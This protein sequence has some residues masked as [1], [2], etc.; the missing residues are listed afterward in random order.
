MFPN[1]TKLLD[2]QLSHQA[3]EAAV[4][5]LFKVNRAYAVEACA[6]ASEFLRLGDFERAEQLAITALRARPACK[7]AYEVLGQLFDQQDRGGDVTECK[8]GKLPAQVFARHFQ[9]AQ[10]LRLAGNPLIHRTEVFPAERIPLPRPGSL[11]EYS[12]VPFNR[13]EINSS[14]SFV[15]TISN[16]CLWHDSSN[17]LIVDDTGHEVVEHT[18]GNVVLLTALQQNYQAQALKGRVILLGAR[19]A[20][21]YY[22]W[23]ADIIPKL[24]IL[25]AAGF[26]FQADDRFVVPN[27]TP[28][29]A[30]A[31]LTRAGITD[32]QLIESELHSPYM[33]ADELIVPYLS[34][35]M[36]YTM[37]QWLPAIMQETI[38]GRSSI[39][40]VTNRKLFV[41]RDAGTAAG[42]TVD[43]QVEV[44]DF[45]VQHGFEVVKPE[46]MSVVQ[47]AQLFTE[48]S[49]VAGPHGAGFSNI[50]YCA[51]TTK[52]IEF[53]GAHIAPCYWAIS[54][55]A[56][57][58]YYHHC[59]VAGDAKGCQGASASAR[60]SAGF[61]IP[62]DAAA[63][64]LQKADC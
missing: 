46:Q 36:G 56:G 25:K 26:V 63:R 59:C 50:V 8:R 9:A 21:N 40:T 20:H 53:Y 62:L 55:L 4:A 64:L 10:P 60:R 34:N 2:K 6:K 42:R 17:T 14:C 45:F 47:Q 39:G 19:G 43:N 15:D 38:L 58:D 32:E 7:L 48:A 37:G 49:V 44:E 57:L 16:A 52:I 41:S 12:Q 54:A 13:Q 29:F 11:V 35:K 24:G 5:G 3:D 31:L 33:T 22:H 1:F 23:I 61:S 51:P 18:Q 30:R 28:G 27:A